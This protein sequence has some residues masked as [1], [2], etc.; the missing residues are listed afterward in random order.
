MTAKRD[1]IR[2]NLPTRRAILGSIFLTKPALAHSKKQVI[3]AVS[4]MESQ[5]ALTVFTLDDALY[6]RWRS[7]RTHDGMSVWPAISPDARAI[8]WS[9]EVLSIKHQDRPFITVDTLRDGTRPV[10]LED[11]IAEILVISSGAELIVMGAL[12]RKHYAERSLLALDLRTGLVVHDLTESVNLFALATLSDMSISGSGKL[13]ALGNREQIQ[14]LEIPNGN[15]VYS[16]EGSFPRLSPDGKRLA[17]I[18]GDRLY[19]RSMADG[20]TIKL[21]PRMRVKGAGGWSPDGRFLLAGAWTKLLAFD[22]RQ[23]VVDTT[24]QEY[25]VIDTLGEGD[26]GEK[27]KWISIRLMSRLAAPQSRMD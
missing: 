4:A 5:D 24:T 13:V 9:E 15:T 22:K 8:C 10:S 12:S 25:G 27:F 7:A 18:N 20:T 3:A 16:G 19:I 6:H 23:I 1:D 2:Q 17:F 14:V 11:Y 21:F 26:Y